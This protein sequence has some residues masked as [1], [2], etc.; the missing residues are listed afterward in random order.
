MS[1]FRDINVT[2]MNLLKL[3]EEELEALLLKAERLND[4]IEEL[5]AKIRFKPRPEKS[6]HSNYNQDHYFIY[7]D[8]SCL[9]NP[10]GPGGWASVVVHDSRIL[11]S[12]AGGEKSSTNNKM[13]LQAPIEALMFIPES[14]IVTVYSDSQYLVKGM[15][16]WIKSWKKRNFHD[17]KND[18]LWRKLLIAE[19][20]HKKVEWKWV[21][22][23]SGNHYNEIVDKMA[24]KQARLN[25]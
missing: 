6:L 3:K 15:T 16:E 21:R 22:G 4:E 19:A 24:V 25:K 10:G 11:H 7:S 23:H 13:E 8:G 1:E 12:F 5:K 2:R 9:K 20:R 14:E 17:V 18:D